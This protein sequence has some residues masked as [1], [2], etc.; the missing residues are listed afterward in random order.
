M[1]SEKPGFE[2]L[3]DAI[4]KKEGPDRSKEG[5]EGA[6][7]TCIALMMIAHL[8]FLKKETGT[9]PTSIMWMDTR[10]ASA[11]EM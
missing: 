8:S 10:F 5:L 6:L 9:H 11:V 2:V 3:Q 7:E 1:G 4:L